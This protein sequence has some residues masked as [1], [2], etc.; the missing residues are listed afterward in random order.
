MSSTKAETGRNIICK[1]KMQANLKTF[2]FPKENNFQ[3]IF[4]PLK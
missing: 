1:E 4:E 3:K 2:N